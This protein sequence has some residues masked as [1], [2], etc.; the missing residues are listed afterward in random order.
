M[1]KVTND[2]LT[3]ESARDRII[4]AAERLFASKGLHGAGLREIARE[5]GV[6]VNL[7][8]YHFNNKDELYI[9]VYKVKSLEI[10]NM[11]ASLLEELD[12]KYSPD[13]P[14]VDELI[15]AFIHPFFAIQARDPE[16]WVNHVHSYMREIGSDVWRTLN[17]NS[18]SPAIRRFAAALHRALPSAD[19][20]D[21]VFVLGMAAQASSISAF[22][23]DHVMIG[24]DK[25][26]DLSLMEAE[27]R[28]VRAVTA[29][30]FE[31]CK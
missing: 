29:A 26:K 19:R 5:A 4:A 24:E 18:L 17:S 22:P 16:G 23:F 12:H 6:S 20:S 3:S 8:G 9:K 7:I 25:K 31:L 30:A 15:R 14:P 10:N 1:K 11:R 28:V 2:A 13:T 27:D 21:I